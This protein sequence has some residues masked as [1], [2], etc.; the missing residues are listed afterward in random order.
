MLIGGKM[1]LDCCLYNEKK[2]AIEDLNFTRLSEYDIIKEK[3]KNYLGK[4]YNAEVG[5]S[6]LNNMSKIFPSTN[7]LF[8]ENIVRELDENGSKINMYTI[9][10]EQLLPIYYEFIVLTIDEIIT[11]IAFD[12]R[13]P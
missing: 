7:F 4:H 13:L 11:S 2:H 3:S 10:S 6:I 1:K 9:K 5:N 8:S 12:Y